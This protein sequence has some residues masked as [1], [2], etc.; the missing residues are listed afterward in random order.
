[1][2]QAQVLE[3]GIV[4][5][6]LVFCLMPTMGAHATEESWQAAFDRFYDA[7]F[8]KTF[9]N[10]LKGLASIKD[11][12]SDLLE[13]LRGAKVER[14]HLAHR[15][16]REHDMDFMTREGR[17]RMI[18]ECEDLIERFGELDQMIEAFAHEQ[19]EKYGFT[20]EW[21]DEKVTA[22]LDEAEVREGRGRPRS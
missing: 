1:M 14:D 4:N 3:H 18:A 11:F 15:F 20:K 19:R 22:M 5:T 10:M 2:S 21:I 6:M 16:F 13:R 8:G 7:E 17:T 9:G 12:P